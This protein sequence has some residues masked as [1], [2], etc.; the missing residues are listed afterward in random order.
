MAFWN[1]PI[2][3]PDYADRAIA[4]SR[5]IHAE[6]SDINTRLKAEIN[7]P[8][9]LDIGIGIATGMVVVGN[10]VSRLRFSYSC[11]GDAVNIAARLESMTKITGIALSVAESTI[12][13][14]R[15]GTDL[16]K[17]CTLPVRGKQDTVIVYSIPPN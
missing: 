14:A 11:L 2:D 5:D 12:K 1:A 16:I 8:H 10:M 17:V 15:A 4:F 3:Q 9:Y 13:A 6:L 7:L